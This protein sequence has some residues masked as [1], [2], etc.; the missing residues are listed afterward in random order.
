MQ[1]KCELDNLS[2]LVWLDEYGDLYNS[3]LI[4]M[5]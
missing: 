4:S 3:I 2:K 1:R 5:G